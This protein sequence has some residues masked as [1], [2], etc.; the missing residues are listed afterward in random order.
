MPEDVNTGQTAPVAP[1]AGMEPVAP[2]T[3][4]EPAQALTAPPAPAGGRN[5]EDLFNE[6][7]ELRRT[8]V[9]LAEK[10]Q[11][12]EY[13][14]TYTRN[15]VETFRPGATRPTEEPP[16]V[17]QVTDEEFLTN[18]AK[19]T[20]RMFESFMARERAERAQKE[21]EQYVERAKSTFEQ[22]RSTAM[23]QLD[24]LMKGI[25]GEVASAVQQGVISGAIKP[26][27]AGD[28]EVWKATA[29]TYRMLNR[30]EYDFGKYFQNSH[31]PPAPVHSEIPSAASPPR[32]ANQLTP[33]QEMLIASGTVT[34]EQFLESLG[35]VR[36]TAAERQR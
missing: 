30:N 23:K 16:Q 2:A 24:R 13:E 5:V 25:E 32:A 27:A 29:M 33:E 26:E 20:A 4:Q 12:A 19:A 28:P 11:R 34:R 6:M 35:K 36:S 22:G 1:P 10:A 17:A 3:Q 14:A 7:E 31:T 8:N 9:E 21:R 15:L 18:P